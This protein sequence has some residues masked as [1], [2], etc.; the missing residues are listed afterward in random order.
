MPL[1]LQLS[2]YLNLWR[3]MAA[4]VEVL[5]HTNNPAGIGSFGSALGQYA[6]A[7]VMVFFVMS[8]TSSPARRRMVAAA[9]AASS[10]CAPR[11]TTR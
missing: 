5:G 10:C 8:A 6:H 3:F 11:G 7:M 2:T 4:A 9:R 1:T